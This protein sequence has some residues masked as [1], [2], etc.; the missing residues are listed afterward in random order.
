MNEERRRFLK[1][2]GIYSIGSLSYAKAGWISIDSVAGKLASLG[3]PGLVVLGIAATTGLTG[4]AALLAAISTMGGPLGILG[5]IVAIAALALA[6]NALSEYSFEYIGKKVV[7]K[8]KEDGHSE[9][10]IREEINGYPISD[11][12]KRKILEV[13]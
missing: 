10:E 1:V 5:G 6:V 8:L 12:L 7:E 13:L 11:D 9:Y 4:G 3:V 2:V